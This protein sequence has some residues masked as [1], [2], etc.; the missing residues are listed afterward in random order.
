MLAHA[1]TQPVD[2]ILRQHEKF[3]RGL[4]SAFARPPPA[5]ARD[6]NPLEP[7]NTL[8][9]VEWLDLVL[10]TDLLDAGFT[11]QDAIWAFLWSRTWCFDD[12]SLEQRA[13]MTSLWFEECAHCP[14]LPHAPPP[15]SNTL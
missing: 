3:L 11:R 4:F 15:P 12:G 9:L 13:K 10:A 6:D 5:S 7:A 2:I 14:L 8:G 1:D